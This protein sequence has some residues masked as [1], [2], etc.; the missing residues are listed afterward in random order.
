M[1][2]MKHWVPALLLVILLASGGYALF[3]VIINDQLN[4]AARAGNVVSVQS[5]LS[6]GASIE[7]RSIHFKTPLMSAA[8]GGNLNAVLFLLSQGA[9]ANAHSD[10][11]SVLIW[12]ATSGNA[13]IV[14]VLIAH[15][16]NVNWRS[17]LGNTALQTAR[18]YKQTTIAKI[19][20][21]AGAKG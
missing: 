6:R 7:G 18:E 10:S 4:T 16:A 5:L 21:L 9:D 20:Q 12:A 17:S 13:G 1:G 15:G 3:R 8:E 14:R 11:G 19:L 2:K